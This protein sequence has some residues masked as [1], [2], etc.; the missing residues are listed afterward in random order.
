MV[1]TLDHRFKLPTFKI[2]KDAVDA[3]M[4]EQTALT[5]EELRTRQLVVGPLFQ[6]VNSVMKK[7]GKDRHPKEA[8]TSL[9]PAPN[10]D[11]LLQ[12]LEAF[13]HKIDQKIYSI[14]SK[15]L[16]STDRPPLVCYYCHR[17]NHWAGR[18]RE[19]AKDKEAGLVEQ[20][21]TN[22]FLPNSALI[23][24]DSSTPIC[25]VVASFQPTSSAQEP[26]PPTPTHPTLSAA[27]TKYKASCGSLQPW[28]P[29]AVSSQS[30]AGAHESDPAG[31]KH[32]KYSQPFKAPLVPSTQLKR[33]LRKMPS[34][35]T[36]LA[37]PQGEDEPE[38]SDRIMNKPDPKPSPPKEQPPCSVTPPKATGQQPK[39]C[40]ERRV[41]CNHPDAVNW[42][43][44]RIF[45]LPV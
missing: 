45:D 21:G 22:F 32:H 19:L 36:D 34:V 40:F 33:Q 13:E 9:K 4:K 16:A 6:E 42:L 31:R 37:Q 7:M 15:A 39:V 27:T 35:A 5:F 26:R 2:L 8:P 10:M 28:Y 44:K 18:C 20:P 14:P 1:T 12:I 38:L 23:P 3:V 30:F 11:K 25:H 29:P 41:S 43:V 24:F 17:K